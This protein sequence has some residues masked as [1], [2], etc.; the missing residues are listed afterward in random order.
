LNVVAR[1]TVQP[2]RIAVSGFSGF[3]FT[4][5]PGQP[6]LGGNAEPSPWGSRDPLRIGQYELLVPAGSYDVWV[7]SISPGL[8]GA[9][10]NTIYPYIPNPGQ[11][12]YWDSSESAT[13]SVTART[14]VNI[15]AGSERND[16]N[17]ILNGT[18]PRFD[19][20][21][22]SFLQWPDAPPAWRREEDLSPREATA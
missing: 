8:E 20:F 12:E 13:D 6:G 3:L 15:T 19:S 2:R 14:P 17:I 1:D 18:P 7:E 10:F 4:T 16:I 9:S 11:N 5:R 22:S 21:E